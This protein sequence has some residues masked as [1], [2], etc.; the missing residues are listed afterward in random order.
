MPQINNSVNYR[1]C[2][3][4]FQKFKH[5]RSLNFYLLK[6]RRLLSV[7]KKSRTINKKSWADLPSFKTAQSA[8]ARHFGGKKSNQYKGGAYWKRSARARL[9]EN[10]LERWSRCD[11]DGECAATI[12]PRSP[13]AIF[14]LHHAE[15][16]VWPTCVSKLVGL[17]K[18]KSLLCW[19][20]L[21]KTR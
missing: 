8:F 10:L 7:N 2:N 18:K 21:Q 11:G 16:I 4:K 12:A 13:P 17:D 14:F 15:D 3:L 6:C 5:S 1:L 9:N 20:F 19:G